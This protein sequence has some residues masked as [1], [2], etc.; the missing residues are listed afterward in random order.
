M[1]GLFIPPKSVPCRSDWRM[2]NGALLLGPQ[3]ISVQSMF[4]VPAGVFY[5]FH[6]LYFASLL[7][8]A[9]SRSNGHRG[10]SHIRYRFLDRLW[11]RGTEPSF[12]DA[13]FQP[14]V[15]LHLFC[16]LPYPHVT[17]SSWHF[18][19]LTITVTWARLLC[20]CPVLFHCTRWRIVGFCLFILILIC[21]PQEFLL[22]LD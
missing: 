19:S 12:T 6:N 13:L 22:G 16:L 10:L 4:W 1:L 5:C 20:C 21:N 14:P 17:I 11:T 3:H 7:R 2:W 15:T 8:H 9:K 18:L